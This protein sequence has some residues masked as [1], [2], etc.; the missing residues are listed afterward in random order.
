[1][2]CDEWIDHPRIIFLFPQLRSR[3]KQPPCL[4]HSTKYDVL[5]SLPPSFHAGPLTYPIVTPS[6]SAPPSNAIAAFEEVAAHQRT[7]LHTPLRIVPADSGSKA[8]LRFASNVIRHRT[9]QT[10]N[11]EKHTRTNNIRSSH[12][13]DGITVPTICVFLSMR[14]PMRA[15]TS[16]YVLSAFVENL[17]FRRPAMGLPSCTRDWVARVK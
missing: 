1:M 2:K 15:F 8:L 14:P 7:V 9:P 12:L 13:G 10:P 17:R 11:S 6:P 16:T 3:H 5:Q 4:R